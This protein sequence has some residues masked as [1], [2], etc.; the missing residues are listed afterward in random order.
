[1][2]CLDI[3]LVN[4]PTIYEGRVE[5]YYNGVW[6]TVCDDGWDLNDAQVVCR[7]LRLGNAVAAPLFAYYGL[8]RGQI[9]L[10]DLKC[11]GSE[12]TIGNCLH[13][14]WGNQNCR[15]AEDASV[16]CSAGIIFVFMDT[17]IHEL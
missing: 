3:R 14:G 5:V 8:G 15:H 2:V 7:Q 17:V 11:S 6:G 4:G 1:M 10:D 9:W 16:K 12:S 13:N